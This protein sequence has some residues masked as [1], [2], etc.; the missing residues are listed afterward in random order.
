MKKSLISTF[1]A[2]ACL[3]ASGVA[4]AADKEAVQTGSVSTTVT[5]VSNVTITLTEQPQTV[6]TEDV[7]RPGVLLTT[8]GIDATGLDLSSAAGG[9]I[10]VEVDSD[11]ID[12]SGAW[13]FKDPT[14]PNSNLKARPKSEPGW[15]HDPQNRI[16][17]RLGGD[18]NVSLQ[19]PIETN[20]G[21]T[22]VTAG[23]YELPVTVS[24]NT[25]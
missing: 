3:T 16:A 20:T 13:L 12:V 9:N 10:A 21:N 11:H 5:G 23:A 15:N 24:Y 25:W 4:M 18:Q 14:Q 19:L 1:I 6:T 7:K 17:Y 2:A 8:L 22:N